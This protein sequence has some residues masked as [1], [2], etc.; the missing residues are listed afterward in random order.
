MN[1][2][3]WRI[4]ALSSFILVLF[5][6]GTAG[7]LTADRAVPVHV[8]KTTLLTPEVA[9]GSFLRIEYS[10]IR[11]RAC[12]TNIERQIIDSKGTRFILSE[13]DLEV[14]GPTG[15]DQFITASQVPAMVHPGPARYRV[16][17]NYSCNIIHRLFWPIT[18]ARPDISFF[19]LPSG[20]G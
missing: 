12:R 1:G 14:V 20:E 11:D 9:Q 8:A 7:M 5:W 4:A 6:A 3:L 16:T 10:V 17:L 2:L 18:D 19:V 15:P 13:T